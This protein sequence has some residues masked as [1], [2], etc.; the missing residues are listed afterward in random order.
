MVFNCTLCGMG[1]RATILFVGIASLLFSAGYIFFSIS[2][3]LA[4]NCQL[5]M[6]SSPEEY[7]IYMYYLRNSECGA[8][9]LTN[10]G[11]RD[12]PN[13][14][15]V[16][17][18][19]VSEAAQR[20]YIFCIV[21]VILFGVWFI[22]S[23]FSLFSICTS[24]IGRCCVA[25][26]IYPYVITLFLVL[27][28]SAVAFVFYLI[29]FI[30][31]FDIDFVLELL[32]IENKKDVRILLR[33]IDEI[34][35]VVPPLI[36]WIT[37]SFGVLFWFMFLTLAFVML[38]VASRLWEENKPAPSYN[39]AVQQTRTTMPAT[40]PVEMTEH[41]TAVVHQ[42]AVRYNDPALQPNEPIPY[43]QLPPSMI[44]VRRTIEPLKSGHEPM[45]TLQVSHVPLSNNNNN[46]HYNNYPNEPPSPLRQQSMVNPYTDKRFSYMPGNPQP[47]SYLAGPSQHPSPRSSTT[48]PEIRKQ[49]PWSYFPPLEESAMPKRVTSTLTEHKE[50]PGQEISA[51]IAKPGTVDDRSSDEGKWS[52]PEYRY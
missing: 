46:T 22:T 49:L 12:I 30:E 33:T 37:V 31:S 29:D 11:I 9:N 40:A 2:G 25:V 10:L 44:D 34:I 3:I 47:F 18:P 24:C 26:G 43:H 20:T 28:Y 48:L 50:F 23:V 45:Q 14:F 27:V 52:G 36:M 32:E 17:V 4:H 16:I 13:D 39:Q 41:H 21:G 7:G 1:P 5:N 6:T 15:K 19:D 8:V 51:P 35:L 38:G 42:S